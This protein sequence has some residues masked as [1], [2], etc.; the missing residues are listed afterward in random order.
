MVNYPLP[1]GRGLQFHNTAIS[2]ASQEPARIS[3]QC[4]KIQVLQHPPQALFSGVRFAEAA[5]T[6]PYSFIFFE[7]LTSRLCTVPHTGQV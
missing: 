7:A 1:E 3:T 5:M 6:S 2:P 4:V